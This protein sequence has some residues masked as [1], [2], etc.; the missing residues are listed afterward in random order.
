L[1]V[2]R[3]LGFRFRLLIWVFG[4]GFRILG[5]ESWAFGISVFG[6]RVIGWFW[7]KE[8]LVYCFGF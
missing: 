6:F 8:I 4:I 3:V 1:G 7:G 2:F 5:S